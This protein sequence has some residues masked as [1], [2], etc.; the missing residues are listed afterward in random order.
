ML[1]YRKVTKNLYFRSNCFFSKIDM[2]HHFRH[3]ISG[4]ELPELFTYPFNYTPHPLCVIASNELQEYLADNFDFTGD[5]KKG[6]MFGVLVVSDAY[7][8][9][10]YLA[11]FSGLLDG[12]SMHPFF[13]PPVYDLT[14]PNGYFREEE[15]RISDMNHTIENL[16]CG[17]GYRAAQYR[18]NECKQQACEAINRVKTE[19]K[20]A[21][22]ERDRRRQVGVS[23]DEDAEMIKDSQ[24]RKAE[25]KR[26]ERSWKERIDVA[27]AELDNI[28]SRIDILKEE[29]K[30]RSAKLQEWLFGQ[31]NMLNYRGET[32]PLQALF[33]DTPQ[34]A[35]PAGAG[36]CAAPRL[37]QYAYLHGMKPLAMAEFWWGNPPKNEVR[38]HG[39]FYPACNGKC[40]PILKHMLVGLDVEPDPMAQLPGKSDE[41]EI[42]YEDQWLMVVHK[43]HD[44]LSVPGKDGGE[45]LY[46]MLR[47]RL[48]DA[49]GPLIVHRL[50]MA[51]S[52]LLVIAKDKDT[53]KA[54]QR[55]FEEHTIVKRYKAIVEGA[56][57]PEEGVIELPL[58]PDYLDRPRQVVDYDNG[59]RAVTHYRIEC[60]TDDGCTHIV[61]TPQTGRTHQLRVHSAHHD[62][63]N[64]PI[65][66]DTLYGKASDRLYLHAESITFTHPVSGDRITI[67]RKADF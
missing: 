60:E 65:K 22:E 34:G 66:G 53:H 36:E 13:V 51:T 64:A 63:L 19:M 26:I 43:P 2:L 59:K 49:T 23:A 35:P 25:L 58:L 10:G 4:I 37:L 48:P 38:I 14:A 27:K 8:A 33:A 67:E 24:F 62:G 55:Q 39:K 40:R 3:S 56:G 6:K 47:R 15:R 57:F 28:N 18:L 9:I 44:M 46:D 11:A 20:S 41:V 42:L 32:Q 31:F 52:G 50:D 16:L 1:I 7:G 21:K 17:D 54:L 29:R 30:Y 61:F 5:G 45:S 12:K